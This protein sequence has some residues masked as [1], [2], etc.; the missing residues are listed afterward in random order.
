MSL[1]P[2]YLDCALTSQPFDT[3]KKNTMHIEAIFTVTHTHA[4]TKALSLPSSTL[5]WDLGMNKRPGNLTLSNGRCVTQE[6]DWAGPLCFDLHSDES[7]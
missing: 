3:H 1:S 5:S 4:H 7:R 6:L 2:F